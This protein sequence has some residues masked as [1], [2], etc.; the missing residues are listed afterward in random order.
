MKLLAYLAIIII[1]ITVIYLANN[2][3]RV[4]DNILG[5]SISVI[6]GILVIFVDN[7]ISLGRNFL[8]SL[9]CYIR[10]HNTYIRFSIA[11]LYRIKVNG[12][13]LLVRGNRLKNQFQPVG[14][15]FQYLPDSTTVFKGIEHKPDNML[16]F[17]KKD[18]NDLRIRIKGK[19]VGKFLKWF[20]SAKDREV[21]P[22]REFCEELLVTKILP[23]S[24]FYYIFYNY[25]GRKYTPV[26][27]VDYIGGF[28]II[29]AEIYELV[30]NEEQLKELENISKKESDDYIFAEE[31][32]I[33]N[34]G[35]V[36]REKFEG[37]IAPTA[38]WII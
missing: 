26:R 18:K 9:L 20:D 27:Y 38:K 34:L 23:I 12:K 21:S 28:E 4:S 14:G 17:S 19:D 33:L 5:V 30:P 36:P 3:Q 37:H 16:K 8:I 35:V 6:A 24:K 22:W 29:I 32:L 2:G 1:G 15:V 10:H 13:Y 7:C 31:N 11:Y 25:I